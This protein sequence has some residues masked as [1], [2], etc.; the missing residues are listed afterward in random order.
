MASK[1]KKTKDPLIEKYKRVRNTI[2]AAPEVQAIGEMVN[3]LI[4][5]G[6]FDDGGLNEGI[7]SVKASEK[8]AAPAKKASEMQASP[9]TKASKR[10]I[11]GNRKPLADFK[12]KMK[13]AEGG[14]TD[15]RKKIDK[16]PPFGVINADDFKALKA[17]KKKSTGGIMVP[18][19]IG[20][21]K[22]T[23]IM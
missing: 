17:M 20:K 5:M 11:K 13:R 16:A 7:K 3:D 4:G 12:S 8:Q 2:I 15:G 18:V 1:K 10:Q 19:K 6:G 22:I 21:N 23:K 9:S 14:F